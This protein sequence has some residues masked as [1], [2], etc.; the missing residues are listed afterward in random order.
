MKRTKRIVLSL[1]L[2]SGLLPVLAVNAACPSAL[3]EFQEIGANLR[4][5]PERVLAAAGVRPGMT[6]GEVGAGRGR[7]TVHLA[8]KVGPQGK[9]YAEDIDTGSLD[10]L[11]ERIA[12]AG[13]ANVEIIVGKVADPLFPNGSLDMVFMILTY[14]H[15]SEPVALLKSL[16]PSLKP[17]ATVVV[18]DPDPEKDHREDD[19]EYT[20]RAK[21]ERE[22]GEAGFEI[23]RQETFLE[24][25]SIFI[26][27]VR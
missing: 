27:R 8:A 10:Y 20:S 23:A 14:H 15:L 7:Y 9:I 2:V 26:L 6:I 1:L 21:I 25:D 11:R 17:G 19:S 13:I 16:V 18:V 24:R 3:Q 22:A 12:K 5:P 4:Q